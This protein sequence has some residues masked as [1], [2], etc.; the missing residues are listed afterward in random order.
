MYGMETLSQY[1]TAEG[2]SQV[3]FAAAVGRTQ[4]TISRL[5]SGEARPSL[6]LALAIEHATSGRV[7]C[8]VWKNDGANTGTESSEV[9]S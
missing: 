7:P 9:A 1:L 5:A 3:T 6:K 2:V 4:A 8:A